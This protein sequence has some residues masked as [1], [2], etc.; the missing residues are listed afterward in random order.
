MAGRGSFG[1]RQF[2]LDHQAASLV[3]I[4]K[5]KRAA[6]L[7]NRP[8]G[9]GQTEAHS[10]AVA[11]PGLGNPVKGFSEEGQL[12]LGNAWP[13]I[14][15][16]DHRGSSVSRIGTGRYA[17]FHPGARGGVISAVAH[18]V[19]NRRP[20]KLPRSGNRQ[21]DKFKQL[22]PGAFVMMLGINVLRYFLD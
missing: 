12:L 14:S 16:R 4:G 17:N 5:A 11:F 22:D 18:D 2:N 19:F 20:E 8:L 10:A 6:V 1:H 9:D 7:D 21:G 15:D 13:V 3:S